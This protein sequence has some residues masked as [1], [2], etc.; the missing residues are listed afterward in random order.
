MR[1]GTN[2]LSSDRG[3]LS[4]GVLV[5][6]LLLLAVVGVAFAFL[7][8]SSG[9]DVER[10]ADLCPVQEN[11]IRGSSVFLVDLRKPVAKDGVGPGELLRQ[12]T[13][14]MGANEE[15]RVVLLMGSSASPRGPLSRL[16]KPY[17]NADLQIDTAK[18]GNGSGLRDCTQLPAQIPPD[19]RESATRFCA[20]RTAL[21]SRLNSLALDAAR[22]E[23][24][25]SN[26]YLVEAIEDIKLDLQ[27]RTAPHVLYLFSDMMQ[28]ARWYSHLEVDWNEWDHAGFSEL[29]AAQPWH[30]GFS[31]NPDLR[32]EVFYLPR[33]GLTDQPRASR[34]HQQFW[35]DYF[36]ESDV[37]FHVQSVSPGYAARPLMNR[38]DEA[39][40]WAEERAAAEEL[41]A[42]IERERES[43][44]RQQEEL[45]RQAARTANEERRAETQRTV[46]TE[47]P[48]SA[49]SAQVRTSSYARG[50]ASAR[51]PD[52]E[53]PT[54][55]APQLAGEGED[56]QHGQEPVDIESQDS[57]GAFESEPEQ[58]EARA[59]CELVLLAANEELSPLYPRGGRMNFGEAVVAVRYVVD[60]SGETVD[61]EIEVVSELSQVDRERYFELFA[62]SAVETV[63]RW[64]F[65]FADAGAQSCTR[66]Q[67]RT[68]S[69]H[70]T[71]R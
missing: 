11:R 70:F 71:Y 59:A 56:A 67:S 60:D 32:A 53:K 15:L 61:Q 23:E 22:D 69:F 57:S 51:V 44:R 1:G 54:P 28:H 38:V 10:D 48:V 55:A 18:D 26:A 58:P 33:E 21:E 34:L 42:Q 63:R 8:G 14:W 41:W 4:L 3:R 37:R 64:R 2:L 7:S 52:A 25:L 46:R 5:P 30:F 9:R 62:E 16:C 35:R 45:A 17:E 29:L 24:E 65:A 66:R 50:N 36:D 13:M 31:G 68:T 19:L 6:P 40:L 47:Q 20:L 12:I 27:L 43:L 39:Q 49:P